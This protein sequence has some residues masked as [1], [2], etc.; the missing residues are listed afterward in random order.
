MNT[1]EFDA[2]GVDRRPRVSQVQ[3]K[4]SERNGTRAIAPREKQK[5][6]I[7]HEE[8]EVNTQASIA[9]ATQNDLFQRG[10][11]LITVLEQIED[12]ATNDF[13]RRP[14]GTP[15]IHPLNE[16]DIRERLTSVASFVNQ[17]RIEDNLIET[18]ARPPTWCYKTIWGKPDWLPVRRLE[19]VLTHPVLLPD[20]SLLTTNGYDAK[21]RIYLSMDGR[22]KIDVPAKPT[23]QEVSEAVKVIED[24][25]CDFPF[26]TKEHKAAFFAALL[27]PIA[28]PSYDGPDPFFLVD[29]NTAGAGKGKLLN[30][31]SSI[32]YGRNFASMA[33]TNN[34]DEFRKRVTALAIG[35]ARSV[36]LDNLEG[37]VG[38]ATFNSALTSTDWEDRVL[39][40]SKTYKGPL[41]MTWYGTGNNVELHED[42]PRRTCVVRLEHPDELPELKSDFRHVD[43]LN[44]VKSNRDK[45]MIALLTMVRAWVVAE[46]PRLGVNKWGSFEGWASVVPEIIVFCGIADPDTRKELRVGS[47]TETACMKGIL[48]EMFRLDPGCQGRTAAKIADDPGSPELIEAFRRLMQHSKTTGLSLGSKFRKYKGKNIGSL[49]I[50]EMG[51]DRTNTVLWGAVSATRPC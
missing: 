45:L 39:N 5:I 2:V 44:H 33:Y 11:L 3:Y 47:D 41:A 14:A 1:E 4:R 37:R 9:L 23:R 46:R 40:L 35:G 31:I 50:A 21:S 34:E 20:G 19:A 38:N 43:V 6:V 13:F 30:V 22:L 32:V 28:K 51:K 29:A 10:G 15:I 24:V 16:L 36:L 17:K 8:N 18:P 48:Q 12:S 27:T 49:K 25:I 7:T 26:Q 42:L